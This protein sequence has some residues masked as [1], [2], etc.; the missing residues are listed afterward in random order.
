M[1]L[2]A[3]STRVWTRGLWEGASGYVNGTGSGLGH[4]LKGRCANKQGQGG[5]V[6]VIFV[7]SGGVRLDENLVGEAKWCRWWYE[8]RAWLYGRRPVWDWT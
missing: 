2:G 8:K 6:S 5:T 3:V 1:S 7:S 4:M